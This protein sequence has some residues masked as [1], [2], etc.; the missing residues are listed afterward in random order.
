LAINWGGVHRNLPL[1]LCL[2][3]TLLTLLRI[4][5]FCSYGID[6]TDES[7]YLVWMSA[8]LLYSASLTQFGYVYHPLYVFS[9]GD[10]ASLRQANV[11]ITFGLAWYLIFLFLKP[12]R[13]ES[14]AEKT[15]LNIVASGFATA[16]LTFYGGLITPNY[17][18]LA[19]QA[20]L[21]ASIGLLLCEKSATPRSTSGWVLIG[22]GGWLAFMAKPSTALLLAI[23]IPIC[24][25]LSRKFSLRW[26]SLA[27]SVAVALL[28]LGAVAIDGSI[29]GFIDRLRVGLRMIVVTSDNSTLLAKI[30]LDDFLLTNSDKL[31]VYSIAAVSF[32]ATL[33]GCVKKPAL[34]LVSAFISMLLAAVVAA[35]S[36]G[37]VIGTFGF[38]RFH[39]ML[40]WSVVFPAIAL[41]LLL[42]RRG[43]AKNISMVRW[44]T[45]LLFFSMPHVCA[46]GT[47]GNYWSIGGA[48]AVFWLLGGL[49][50]LEPVVRTNGGWGMAAPL[51]L[52]TQLVVGAIL[53]TELEQPYR[54][55][56]PLR[57]NDHF[58]EFGA[59]GSNLKLSAEYAEYVQSA[60]SMARKAGFK[61]GT[62]IIDL[63][64]QSPGILYALGAQ[65][66]GQAWTIGGYSGSSERASIGMSRVSCEKIAEAWIL[67][68][69]D[70]PR[71][72]PA[73]VM[74]GQGAEFPEQ[75][76]QVATWHTA[77]GSGGYAERRLQALY[78][79]IAERD[80]LKACHAS[81]RAL[82][83]VESWF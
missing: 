29:G 81:D 65:A 76:A 7:Y 36:V 12:L 10:V 8:P 30:R 63:T 52:A 64:G 3:G 25:L 47:D 57:L 66:I 5:K 83:F 80:V 46:F 13:F 23:A 24:L 62:P 11:L 82:R 79:P 67:F 61:S 28:V 49:V 17:N 16:S 43:L 18:S 56:D 33:S 37:L 75:Y 71:S 58:V 22:F 14:A 42:G 77:K 60:K 70:G 50:F 54:Q 44:S 32:V 55:P 53:Q 68:E 38:G 48:A 2:T 31:A 26:I 15:A 34:R 40:I 21:V 39:G 45:A 35:L 20:L 9:G 59:S 4:S 74:R 6:F 72:I 69:P 1:A 73:E 27:A 78:R 51:V 41:G 19:L